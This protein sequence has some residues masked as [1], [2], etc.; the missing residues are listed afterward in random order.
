MKESYSEDVASH[1]GPELYAGDG[2]IAGVATTGVHAGQVL[3]SE[4]RIFPCADPFRIVG[5]PHRASRSW[6]AKH[7]H[8][9][10]ED[11]VHVWK[12]Q[13][14]EP[15]DPISFRPP[16]EGDTSGTVRKHLRWYC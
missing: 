16:R 14:R 13:A 7:G 15:G 12:L 9:G 5:R 11:P 10:V 1:A 3:S 4:M 8:G 2:N 6:R